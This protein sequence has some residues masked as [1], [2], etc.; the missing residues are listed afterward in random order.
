MDILANC[1]NPLC[2]KPLVEGLVPIPDTTTGNLRVHWI[3]DQQAEP[4]KQH[5]F[6]SRECV[7]TWLQIHDPCTDA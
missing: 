7:D 3:I 1:E 4:P 5:L 2:G 6:C